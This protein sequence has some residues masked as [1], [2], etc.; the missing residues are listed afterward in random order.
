MQNGFFSLFLC[1]FFFLLL[2][3]G[4][5]LFWNK[6]TRGHGQCCYHLYY[7]E[8]FCLSIQCSAFRVHSDHVYVDSQQ[9]PHEFFT[10]LQHYNDANVNFCIEFSS[11]IFYCWNWNQGNGTHPKGKRNRPSK[12]IHSIEEFNGRN[13]C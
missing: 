8:R 13:C 3:F 9:K 2:S 11:K 4:N 1:A 6:E 5:F 10:R 12:N 7:P